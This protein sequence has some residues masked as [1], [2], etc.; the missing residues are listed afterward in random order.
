MRRNK[1]QASRHKFW[2]T[3]SGRAKHTLRMARACRGLMSSDVYGGGKSFS[4]LT[5]SSYQEHN[6]VVTLGFHLSEIHQLTLIFLI[7][8]SGLQVFEV[9]GR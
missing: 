7:V 5:S 6:S 1:E 2:K 9:L 4:V 3:G 8:D